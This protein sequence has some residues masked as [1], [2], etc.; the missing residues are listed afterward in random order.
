MKLSMTLSM[1]K[2][3]YGGECLARAAE[4][5]AR[6]GKAIFVPLT[7]PGETVT[8]HITEERRSFAKAEVDQILTASAERIAPRCPHFGACGGCHYQHADAPTQLN[9]KLQI[10]R[11]TLSRAGVAIPA[12]IGVL[13][14]QPWAYRNR[15]RLALNDRGEV[16]Y[17][18]RRSHSIIPVRECP[19]AAPGLIDAARYIASFLTRHPGPSPISELELFTNHDET[20]LLITLFCER[21]PAREAQSWLTASSAALSQHSTGLRLQCL[22][23]S[24]NPQIL[25]HSGQS[26][27]QY[28]AAGTRY[29]V[30]HGAFFQVNRWLIDDFT[31]LVTARHSGKV[32]WD[33]FA[34]V[35][36]FARQLHP[37]FE[38]VLAVES[39]P[40]SFPA[41]ESNLE[42]TNSRAFGLTTLD[43]LR[44]NRE[45]REPRP[46]LIVLDPPRIGLGEE[47]TSLL[48][49]IHAPAM[50]YVSCDPATLARDL[51]ALTNERYRIDSLT[52]VDM[53]PQ[54]FHI[55]AVVGLNR[56]C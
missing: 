1:E 23:G 19:I 20:Q 7:L 37:S 13:S 10:L 14:G 9:L 28:L 53:F 26:S 41:L 54:T 43:F 52:L 32:A 6:Q 36:L 33:L 48:N 45:Q 11:E 46:D 51:H 8:A 4:S 3:V 35:G 49:A 39:A 50:V 44:R 47:T 42:G 2:P 18:G 40:A 24:P 34:G 5:E 12:E 16:G 38:E 31:R 29:R 27:L 25:A 30:D 22:D 21:I 56:A 15:I 17:R 55:E